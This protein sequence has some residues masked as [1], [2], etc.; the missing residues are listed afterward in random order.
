MSKI[1][2][3][4]LYLHFQDLKTKH[5][6]ETGNDIKNNNLN[7]WFFVFSKTMCWPE[8]RCPVFLKIIIYQILIDF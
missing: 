4:V 3:K 7:S 8:Q 5:K 1:K 6:A 2:K